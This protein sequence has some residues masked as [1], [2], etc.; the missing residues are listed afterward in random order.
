MKKGTVSP[1]FT[2]QILNALLTAVNLAKFER[3][4]DGTSLMYW[5]I[6]DWH[7]AV[8]LLPISNF[9]FYIVVLFNNM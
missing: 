8:I 4:L 6:F 9:L 3:D 2:E 1:S 5:Y 7:K